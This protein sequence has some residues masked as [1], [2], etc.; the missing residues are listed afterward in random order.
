MLLLKYVLTIETNKTNNSTY[1]DYFSYVYPE[2]V[3]YVSS[4]DVL[5]TDRY[6]RVNEAVSVA[7]VGFGFIEAVIVIRDLRKEDRD[8][9]DNKSTP[10][11]TSVRPPPIKKT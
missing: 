9:S 10:N 7:L 2:N 3:V 4:N 11:D 8:Q 6:N 1:T 5:T